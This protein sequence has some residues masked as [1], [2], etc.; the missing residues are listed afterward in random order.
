MTWKARLLSFV[1]QSSRI[2]RQLPEYKFNIVVEDQEF[3]NISLLGR[4][5]SS[6]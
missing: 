2:V 4:T 6:I 3:Y 1:T 5:F